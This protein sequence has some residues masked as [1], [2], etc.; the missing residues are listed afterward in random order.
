MKNTALCQRH[1]FLLKK[2]L[3]CFW[4]CFEHNPSVENVRPVLPRNG[5]VEAVAC[6]RR[7]LGQ[8]LQT[9]F[10]FLHYNHS[11]FHKKN[12]TGSEANTNTA[13]YQVKANLNVNL[14]AEMFLT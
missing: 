5:R 14:L 8:K 12:E 1:L 9:V 4:G 11:V 6:R 7:N 2:R 13:R 3:T 10:H